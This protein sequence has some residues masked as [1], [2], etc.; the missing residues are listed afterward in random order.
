MN[1]LNPTIVLREQHA[2]IIHQE[3][4]VVNAR[5]DMRETAKIMEQDAVQNL[6]PNQGKRSY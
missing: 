3:A 1:A 5:Q 2:I 6:V 4:I